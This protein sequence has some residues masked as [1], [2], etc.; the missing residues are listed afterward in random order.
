MEYYKKNY[1][2]K[3]QVFMFKTNFV[4]L[5]WGGTFEPGPHKKWESLT[6]YGLRGRAQKVPPQNK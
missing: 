5:F 1:E 6:F 3:D 4:H 2:F